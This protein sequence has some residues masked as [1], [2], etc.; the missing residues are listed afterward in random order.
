MTK[1]A[2]GAQTARDLL[3][4]AHHEIDA[5]ETA[6]KADYPSKHLAKHTIG[7]IAGACAGTL[8]NIVDWLQNTNHPPTMAALA[9]AGFTKAPA[10]RDHV[11]T[12]TTDLTLCL[13][14]TNWYQI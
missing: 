8:W 9:K 5:L 13:A 1:R 2:F 14:I 11:K 12:H 4:R 7:S 10:V 3:D 6:M